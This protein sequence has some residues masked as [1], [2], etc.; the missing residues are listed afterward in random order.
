MEGRAR[1]PQRCPPAR[2]LV[3][4]R[5]AAARCH[6]HPD[7]DPSRQA[8]CSFPSPPSPHL[9]GHGRRLCREG[10]CHSLQEGMPGLLQPVPDMGPGL[11]GSAGLQA[12]Y[13]VAGLGDEVPGKGH[14]WHGLSCK[15]AVFR[16]QGCPHPHG[17]CWDTVRRQE[18]MAGCGG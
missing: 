5:E 10:R 6:V 8:L 11:Q 13:H 12:R 4:E 3:E 1:S 14:I 2:A 9:A 7:S 16:G 15:A 17:L 18:R